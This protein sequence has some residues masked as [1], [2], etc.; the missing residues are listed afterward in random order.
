MLA[1]HEDKKV[2]KK[3]SNINVIYVLL[4]ILAA[5]YIAKYFKLII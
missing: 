2:T 3:K 1:L 5:V 4:V